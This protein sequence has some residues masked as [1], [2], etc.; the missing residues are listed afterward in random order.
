MRDNNRKVDIREYK[1]IVE[2]LGPQNAPISLAKFQ[3]LKYN[4]SERYERLKDVVYIQEKFKNG[5]WLDKINHEKQARH[6]QSTSPSGKSYF[7][8]DVD[9]NALY[10]K[11][12]MTGFL[13][14]NRKGAQTSNEKVDLFEDRPLG[15]DV[16]TGKPV[17]AMTIKY[18][19]T[20]AHLIP[21]YYERGD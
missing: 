2:V 5:T 7:Y 10:D 12:K 16:Y 14:T 15:I 6:I 3:E 4:D 9:V 18:S 19:K 21:T 17:N 1:K 8:D 20:G 11:Y 13:E